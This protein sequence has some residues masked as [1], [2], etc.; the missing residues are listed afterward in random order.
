MH[1]TPAVPAGRELCAG[2]GTA[3]TAVVKT[4]VPGVVEGTTTIR[5]GLGSTSACGATCCAAEAECLAEEQAACAAECTGTWDL[6][7]FD[8][9]GARVAFFR[10]NRAMATSP[11]FVQVDRHHIILVSVIGFPPLGGAETIYAARDANTIDN[12]VW[13]AVVRLLPNPPSAR[14]SQ[15]PTPVLRPRSTPLLAR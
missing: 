11:P 15:R 14:A 10:I 13:N 9:V 8:V 6:P 1:F 2:M 5:G 12:L 7:W 3:I 4:L